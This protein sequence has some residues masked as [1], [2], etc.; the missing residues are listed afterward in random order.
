MP[1]HLC[2]VRWHRSLIAPLYSRLTFG[3]RDLPT[4]CLFPRQHSEHSDT[5][6]WRIARRTSHEGISGSNNAT[7]PN[8]RSHKLLC[9]SYRAQQ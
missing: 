4:D 1:Y 8:V 2:C 5:T 3:V 9:T 6:R 7:L